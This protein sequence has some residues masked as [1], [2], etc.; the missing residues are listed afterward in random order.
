MGHPDEGGEKMEGSKVYWKEGI[1]LREV[2]HKV[3]YP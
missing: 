1:S 2:L 3:L